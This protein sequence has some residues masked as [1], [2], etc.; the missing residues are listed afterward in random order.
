MIP[1]KISE[2]KARR[3]LEHAQLQQ[4]ISRGAEQDIALLVVSVMQDLPMETRQ[5]IWKA[6]GRYFNQ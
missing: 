6:V 1:T 2:W 4:A 3:D 5:R